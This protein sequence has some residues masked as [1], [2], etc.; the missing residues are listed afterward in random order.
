[1]VVSLYTRLKNLF[2]I[3]G[4][5]LFVICMMLL[6]IAISLTMPYLSLFATEE[7]G[8]S[9]G[10][11]GIFIAV[12]SLSGVFV[13]SFI[14]ERSD[15]RLDRKWIIVMAM[16]SSVLGYASY[17]VFHNY[18]I[19]L[20]TVTVFNGLGAAA[21]PQI[22]AYAQESANKS[23]SDDKTLAMSSLRS[24]FSLGFL[25][26][27]LGATI[28]LGYFGYK[29][30]FI[31]TSSIFLFIAILIFLFLQKRKK[32]QRNTQR[33]KPTNSS[34][35]KN[36]NIRL[37]YIA[38]I[39]LFA[40][41]A[42]NGINTPLFI[43]KDLHGT[44]TDVGLVASIC[45]G[46]EIPIM[47]GLGALS[48]KISN[49]VLMISSCFIGVIY[50][51]ILSVSTHPWQLITAQ[52]IQAIYVAIIMGNGL[53]YFSDLLPHSPGL[54]ATIYSNGSTIGRLV[55]SLG[56]GI[57]AQFIGFRL[58]NLVCVAIAILSFFVLW[59]IKPHEETE[60]L[61]SENLTL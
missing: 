40:V 44:T 30:L 24:L 50:Y 10:A 51:I 23:N 47:I 11:F 21:M 37:P 49:H 38:F 4:Y 5:R 41:N 2:E 16:L 19:L 31:G 29:G 57:I 28:V 39:F 35:F 25:I 53:S 55:G 8:M 1:M 9:T 56:G 14:A 20:I 54:S 7:F 45:A 52:L 26:G 46:L 48:K 32:V 34:P 33:V 61:I 43:V 27:P 17:L 22:F 6:G 59:R 13:N 60:E 3:E 18:F 15:S 42:I 12:S 58:V 36:R